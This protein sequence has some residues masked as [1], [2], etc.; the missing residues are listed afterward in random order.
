MNSSQRRITL[1][2]LNDNVRKLGNMSKVLGKDVVVYRLFHRQLCKFR[3]RSK[4]RRKC[5]I[6]EDK[7]SQQFKDI[8]IPINHWALH[9]GFVPFC[10]ESGKNCHV[11]LGILLKCFN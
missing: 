10:L 6:N 7:L 9:R 8:L 11:T 2:G 3:K 5:S 1:R 4:K